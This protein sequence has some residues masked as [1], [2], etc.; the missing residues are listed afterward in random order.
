VNTSL[1][2]EE[3][4]P[5]NAQIEETEAR[6]KALEAE[7]C[8]IDGELDTHLALKERFEALRDVCDALERLDELDAGKLFWSELTDIADSGERLELLRSRISSFEGQ[9]QGVEEHRDAVKAKIS[10]CLYD[11]G[12]LDEEV[13]QA[14]AREERRQ[15]EFVIEREMAPLRFLPMTM[16][17]NVQV[18]NERHFRKTLIL[19]M[20][21]SVMLG[22]IIPMVALPIIDRSIE[23]VKIPERLVTLVKNEPLIPEP[24]QPKPRQEP[25][26]EK[27]VEPEKPK[28]AVSEKTAKT[29]KKPAKAAP[30]KKAGGN[31]TK[32][33]RKKAE[34]TGVL[35][36][37]STFADLMDEVPVAK[38]GTD[39]RV[40]KQ[41]KLVPGQS[42]AQRNLVAM[43]AKSGT[44]G[45]ISNLGVSRNLGN[46]GS[47]GSGG[48]GNAGQI[49]GVGYSN[50]ESS[51]AGIGGEEGRPMSGGPGPGRTDEEIQIVFDRYKATLYRIYNKELRKDPT[52]RGKLLLKITIEPEGEVSMCLVE[53]TDLGSDYL[54][55]QIVARVKRFNFGPKE[56]VPVTTILYP[57]DFLPAT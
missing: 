46:G 20:F 27:Q 34:T 6:V 55:T 14:Y 29:E 25:K 5:L 7:L 47:G 28:Q 39:A 24:V 42:Q 3:L 57:I 12:A 56:D 17:W 11:L 21:F 22:T 41:S 19:C 52:L 1:L 31:D 18:E 13:R 26:K 37:K 43:Q 50:V 4:A 32:V 15:E 40:N 10:D 33:A 38:L 16:P 44:S 48:Y 8:V 53:S 23:V 35:A 54:V 30:A 51:V 45:G 2:Y 36:F 9:T 49:G